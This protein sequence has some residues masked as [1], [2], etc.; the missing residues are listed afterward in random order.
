AVRL[1]CGQIG[2]AR[3]SYQATADGRRISGLMSPAWHLPSS[4]PPPPPSAPAATPPGQRRRPA[5][6][7][8]RRSSRGKNRG[9]PKDLGCHG[10]TAA[11]RPHETGDET[12]A[13]D[14][15]SRP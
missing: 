5:C 15:G 14:R 3:L 6:H 1:S 7:H 9:S 2:T 12:T 11:N 4:A 13:R 8:G 10:R